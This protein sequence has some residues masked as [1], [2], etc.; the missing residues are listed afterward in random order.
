MGGGEREWNGG[1]LDTNNKK[2]TN[3]KSLIRYKK[4]DL[5]FKIYEWI[6]IEGNLCGI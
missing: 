6:I 4:Y 2:I 1:I 5:R 3:Q